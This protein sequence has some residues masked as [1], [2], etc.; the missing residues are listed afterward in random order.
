MSD[1]RLK[2]LKTTLRVLGKLDTEVPKEILIEISQKILSKEAAREERRMK[3]M[4]EEELVRHE[5]RTRR[6]LRVN[7]FDGR[8]LQEK[9]NEATFLLALQEAGM[10]QLE[11]IDH[12]I[13]RHNPLFIHD[14]SGRRTEGQHRH[15]GGGRIQ[16]ESEGGT[17]SCLWRKGGLLRPAQQ[18]IPLSGGQ[19][20]TDWRWLDS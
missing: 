10:D 5:K 9:T 18:K 16:V 3:R 19:G 15:A 13:L 7:T 2:D 14:S 4:S 17:H 8:I 20:H 1:Q 11:A 6:I 12:L